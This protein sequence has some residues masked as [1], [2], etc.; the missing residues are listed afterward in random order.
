MI[1]V[2][3]VEDEDLIRK[4]LAYTIDWSK[5]GCTIVGEAKNGQEG[6]EKIKELK[7]GLVITDI[8]M[9]IMDGLE[10]LQSLEERDFEVI[11]I[12]GHSEFEYAKR[13]IKLNVFDYLLKPI[14]EN[15]LC[16]IVIEVTKKITDKMILSQLKDNIKDIKQIK[17]LD[18]EFYFQKTKYQYKNTWFIIDYIGR[19]YFN[20]ISIEDIAMELGVSAGY[21]SKKFKKD[22]S[23][24]F[25]DFLNS[26]RIQKS[27]NFLIEGGY[28][29][30]EIAEMVGFSDYKYFSQVF[31]SYMKCSP[32]EFM[33]SNV[34]RREELEDGTTGND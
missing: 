1:N 19:N 16:E 4:G 17:V 21:L 31:K 11:I 22:T 14:N 5:M 7:P 10:M 23:H 3:I 29:V 12:T 6:L 2:L 20:K 34:F 13:A 9:P 26:Y 8:K 28:K 30:Y 33:K 24:T 27:I 25:N 32:M 18:T 15:K